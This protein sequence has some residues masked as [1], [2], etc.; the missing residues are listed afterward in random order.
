MREEFEI[1][2]SALD[3][4]VKPYFIKRKLKDLSGSDATFR[5]IDW[6]IRR[7]IEFTEQKLQ[8]RTV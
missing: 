1:K 5:E 3:V 7:L 4:Q 8:Y 2:G 6:F